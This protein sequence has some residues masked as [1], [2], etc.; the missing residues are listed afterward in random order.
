MKKPSFLARVPGKV[1]NRTVI[2]VIDRLRK[3]ERVIKRN[4]TQN[5]VSNAMAYRKR[6]S[7]K[8]EFRTALIERQADFTDM[9]LGKSTLDYSGCEVIAVFNLLQRFDGG[10]KSVDLPELIEIF[11]KDG[12]L[13]AGRFGVSPKA[14]C[15]YLTGLGIEVSSTSDERDFD[16]LGG[17]CDHF[18]LT[19][20]NDRENIFKQV[21]TFYISKEKGNFISHNAGLRMRY[22]S[23]S[24]VIGALPDGRAKGIFLI[25]VK[26]PEKE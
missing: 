2:R 1:N 18:I 13:H 17:F 14:I 22:H 19:V 3:I 9:S 6:I 16:V 11:E 8:P 21:H 7:E 10:K 20:M 15:E 4:F 25:G 26:E 12:I 23:V 24:E 5:D